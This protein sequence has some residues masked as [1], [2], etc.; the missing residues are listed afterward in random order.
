MLWHAASAQAQVDQPDPPYNPYPP[1]PGS[2][3]PTV[4]PPDLQPKIYRVRREVQT[5][6]H[7]GYC[8]E[9]AASLPATLRNSDRSREMG[10]ADTASIAFRIAEAPYRQLFEL[11][12]GVDFDIRWPGNTDKICSTPGGNF[13]T[14]MPI[15]LSPGD[16]TKANNIYD[17]WG[18]SLSMVYASSLALVEVASPRNTR[19]A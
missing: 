5:I 7:P 8:S 14:A 2:T 6:L 1:L 9:P 4:L 18:Q 15:A 17:H 16:R 11:V 3:P 12:S 19:I 10:F 13:P